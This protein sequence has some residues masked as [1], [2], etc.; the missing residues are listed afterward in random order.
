MKKGPIRSAAPPQLRHAVGEQRIEVRVAREAQA[1]DLLD[2]LST[3]NRARL[4][5]AIERVFDEFDRPGEVVRVE[6][7]DLDLGRIAQARLDEVEERLVE[8]LRE[9]LRRTLSGAGAGSLIPVSPTE[10]LAVATPARLALVDAFAH[11]LA[12]GTWPYRGV[13]AAATD[14]VELFA[15]L[16]EEAPESLAAMLR[17][18]RS[19]EV[20]VRRLVRQ[21][22]QALLERLLAL[23]DPESAH[24]ILGYMAD[25]RAAQAAEPLVAQP[26]Q[27]FAR[28]LWL[29]VL[30]DALRRSGLRANRRAF[31]ARLIEDIAA[32]AG[33]DPADLL[34]A[35][36]RGLAAA[37]S[38]ARG[39][40]SLLSIL[41]EIGGDGVALI[42]ARRPAGLEDAAAAGSAIAEAAVA[43]AAL[44]TALDQALASGLSF[45]AATAEV[46]TRHVLGAAGEAP[47]HRLLAAVSA[48]EAAG[49]RR[50]LRR[51]VAA[52]PD[53]TVYSLLAT[54]AA[55]EAAELILPPHHAE[56]AA[57][58]I[59]LAGCNSDETA[60]LLAAAAAL[61]PSAPAPL[62]LAELVGRLAGER[63]IPSD[64]L[65]GRVHAAAVAAG[66]RDRERLAPLL[67]EARD[68][69]GRSRTAAVRRERAF[70]LLRAALAGGTGSPPPLAFE[71]ALA[72]LA[73]VRAD[74]I[75]RE[76]GAAGLDSSRTAVALLRLTPRA[77]LRLL[78]LLAPR[79]DDRTAFQAVVAEAGS[80]RAA[81]AALAAELLTGVPLTERAHSA[82][83]RSLARLTSAAAA[84]NRAGTAR[85]IFLLVRR[86]PVELIRRLAS[87]GP[88][89]LGSVLAGQGSGARGS[90]SAV[91]D[92]DLIALLF[93]R[94]PA[95]ERREAEAM[96]KLLS[97]PRARSVLAAELVIG[98]LLAAVAAALAQRRRESFASSWRAELSAAASP[99][100]RRALERLLPTPASPA[101]GARRPPAEAPERGSAAWLL[102]LLDRPA[103]EPRR[104]LALLRSPA[105][106]RRL[107]LR[108]PRHLM[109][110]LLFAA[111]PR[112]AR[113]LLASAELIRSGFAAEGH[114]LAPEQL[115]EALLAGAAAPPG[116]AV[117]RL[118]ER[119]LPPGP[120]A[121]GL[122][123]AL[124]A[125]A[126][127]ARQAPLAAAVEELA[128]TL[129]ATSRPPPPPAPMRALSDERSRFGRDESEA[130]AVGNAGLV[131][132]APF[133]PQLFERVG[134]VTTPPGGH[135]SWVAPE[136][137]GRGIHLLQSLVDGRTDAPEPFLALNKILCGLDPSWP[138]PRSIDPTELERAT[139]ASLLEAMIASWPMLQGSSVEALQE[140]FLQRE[141]R[142]TRIEVGWKLEVER[143]TLDVLLDGLPWSYSMILAPWMNEPVSVSW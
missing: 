77:L 35:L 52:A 66:G 90:G 139:C 123:V 3:L 63:A 129:A 135:P 26:P 82:T 1:H 55:E 85:E 65:L 42:G 58:L 115:W 14:P 48:A 54:H 8:A 108:L 116:S 27:E 120:P 71:T 4:L 127:A 6:R 141:G 143:K 33:L 107:A 117:R 7:L 125:R 75:R 124:L 114:S 57:G 84:T 89:G 23:L 30:R 68:P 29:V 2:R 101:A 61:P 105:L 111:R 138:S 16:I 5:P 10:N 59:R 47:A 102:A 98:S 62:V 93:D 99:S 34:R 70:D 119:L 131:I 94:L 73:G 112:E 22:P 142:L 97:G 43:L 50:L 19:S 44:E 9:A 133:F 72:S 122:S 76:V 39:D 132:A 12:T 46:A 121:K 60:A 87:R 81:L 106:R 31:V 53:W 25:T 32:A 92:A 110:R 80:D 126:R 45:A 100:E 128:A 36:R 79:G 13:L 67:A 38:A 40:A 130:V 15:Q 69:A 88:L 104:E 37:P 24:W 11:Y 56:A 64:D 18:R 41:A 96:A 118:L 113:A 49:L 28:T 91:P 83:A 103:D 51:T 20:P 137:A 21:I 78:V 74:A 136:A 95:G 140:T 86:D 17:D 109:V 134:L